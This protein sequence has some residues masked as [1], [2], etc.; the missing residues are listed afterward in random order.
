MKYVGKEHNGTYGSG[1]FCSVACANTRQSKNSIKIKYKCSLCN[2]EYVKK[3]KLDKHYKLFHPEYKTKHICNF[4]GI[5]FAT[6]SKLGCHI[7]KQCELNPNRGK[8]KNVNQRNWK[9]EYCNGIFKSRSLLQKH[10]KE[11]HYNQNV[12]RPVINGKCKFCDKIFKYQNGLTVHERSCLQNPN[13]ISGKSHPL[14]EETKK[15]LSEIAIKRLQGTHCNWLNKPKSYAE[16]YFDTIFTTAQTQY[17]VNRY[18]LDYAW[19]DTKTYIEVDGEQHYTE[20]GL[21]HD[22]IRTEFLENLGWSCIIRIRWSLYNKLKY[23]DKIKFI[24]DIDF[25][26]SEEVFHPVS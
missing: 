5:E 4:C 18:V 21:E 15:K 14:S 3:Q 9:C 22:R 19:P 24:E 23:E 13:R 1:R 26:R 8:Q 20:K 17:R 11:I 2:K 7:S 16:E 10:K 25:P 6:G 12:K